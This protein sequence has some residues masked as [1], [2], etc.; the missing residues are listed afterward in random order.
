MDVV[1]NRTETARYC[2]LRKVLLAKSLKVCLMMLFVSAEANAVVVLPVPQLEQDVFAASPAAL[3]QDSSMT[4]GGLNLFANS[5]PSAA[6]TGTAVA[7]TTISLVGPPII[8]AQAHV[9]S[10]KG[11][12]TGNTNL[13]AT[14]NA[15]VTYYLEIA[16]GVVGQIPINVFATTGVSVNGS[17]GVTGFDASAT[18][19]L[20]NNVTNAVV[21]T[22]TTFDQN[23]SFHSTDVTGDFVNGFRGG[24]NLA[25]STFLAIN[26]LYEVDMVVHASAGIDAPFP[27][28]S[29]SIADALAF[30]DPSFQLAAG[31]DPNVYHLI[32]SPGIQNTAPIS[33]TVPEPETYALMLAGL[34]LLGFATRRRKHQAG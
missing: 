1:Q 25:V 13:V 9:S 15:D 24:T 14:G 22:A 10:T 26:T 30:V 8:Q 20:I 2:N 3:L 23:G 27:D 16:S 33:T 34:G 29:T 18:F 32:F 5:P 21:L 17:L 4:D 11:S 31:Y 19:T 28:G 6:A 7:T 12:G